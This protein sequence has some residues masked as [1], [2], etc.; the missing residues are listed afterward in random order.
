MVSGKLEYVQGNSSGQ[1]INTNITV[2]SNTRIVIDVQ[3]LETIS[4]VFGCRNSQSGTNTFCLFAMDESSYRM[5]KASS[6]TTI[7]AVTADRNILDIGSNYVKVNDVTTNIPT[8]FNSISQKL[9]LF[10]VN[11]GGVADSRSMVRIYSAKIYSG[12]TLLRDYIPYM[13]NDVPGLYDNVNKVFYKSLRNSLIAGPL[14]K[15]GFNVNVN[16]QWKESDNAYVNVNGQWK[17]IDSIYVNVNG[18]WKESV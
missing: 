5:D 15:S 1:Y 8:A 11:S 17:E 3:V 16:G 12:N 2:N 9:Y 10:S 7:N 6:K 4:C 14:I 18:V 13:Q